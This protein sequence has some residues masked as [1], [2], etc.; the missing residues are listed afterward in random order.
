[1]FKQA[2]RNKSEDVLPPQVEAYARTVVATQRD[3][4]WRMSYKCAHCGSN[5]DIASFLTIYS[6]GSSVAKHRKGLFIKT[7]WAETRKQ[8]V[9]AQ[10]CAPPSKALV[11]PYVLLATLASLGWFC[12]AQLHLWDSLVSLLGWMVLANV[13]AI[14]LA[15]SWNVTRYLKLKAEWDNTY[16][17]RRCGR[18]S[19][20]EAQ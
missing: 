14:A 19:V 20:I 15:H 3:N 2:T 18:V 6:N 16:F 13:F 4:R 9:L 5:R 7:G 1:M 10:K 17:C 12:S 11:L 8:S